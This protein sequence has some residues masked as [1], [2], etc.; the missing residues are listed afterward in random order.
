MLVKMIGNVSERIS[1]YTKLFVKVVSRYRC[2]CL[3]SSVG[4]I[5]TAERDL[6]NAK[7]C[8]QTVFIA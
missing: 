5:G 6:D 8:G 7:K 4:R 1:F 3:C 2:M